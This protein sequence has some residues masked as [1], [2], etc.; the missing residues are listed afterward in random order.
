MPLV[1]RQNAPASSS[2]LLVLVKPTS[3]TNRIL[4]ANTEHRQRRKCNLETLQDL[5]A[6]NDDNHSFDGTGKDEEDDGT[7]SRHCRLS[8]SPQSSRWQKR[9]R[10]FLFIS[11][12]H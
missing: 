9:K 5:A 8:V 4:I 6:G 10:W 7:K 3:V 2:Y 11:G 1:S 12:Q